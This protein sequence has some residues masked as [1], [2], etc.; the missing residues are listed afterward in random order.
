MSATTLLVKLRELA[1]QAG[2]NYYQRVKIID[3]LLND[4]QWV[5]ESFCGDDYKAAQSLETDY[6][7]DLSGSI[8]VWQLVGI[9]RKF[10]NESGWKQHNY[11]LRT[12]LEKSKPEPEK[13]GTRSSVK[14]AQFL[15][16]QTR[17]K[18]S[19]FRVKQFEKEV[20]AKESELEKLRKRVAQLE[21]E[22]IRLTAQVEELE[23][24]IRRKMSA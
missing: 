10:P 17:L 22:N 12:L 24:L 5:S 4:R 13:R 8:T 20:V 3:Q 11:N 2:N 23:K 7:H 6:L 21:T 14:M 16:V 19:E 1:D 18:D 9:Y 15:A